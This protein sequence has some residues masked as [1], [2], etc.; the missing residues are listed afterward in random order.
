MWTILKYYQPFKWK[1][2]LKP[3]TK[4]QQLRQSPFLSMITSNKISI[5]N[6]YH[7]E[8]KIIEL[9]T[10]LWSNERKSHGLCPPK[11]FKSGK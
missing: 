1:N 4:Y 2:Y 11:L 10:E 8:D 3:L 5:S 6:L 7:I 9:Y